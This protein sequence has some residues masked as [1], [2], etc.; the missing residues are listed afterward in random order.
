MFAYIVRRLVYMIPIILGV[1]ILVFIL[2]STVGEDPVRLALGQHASEEAI[3][4]LQH[5]WG[6][7]QP[8]WK[9]YLNFLQQVVTFEFGR[10]FNTGE[11]LNVMFREGALISLSVTAPP[12]VAGIFIN[13]G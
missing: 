11:S 13:T 6:L 8:Y 1:S 4:Q 3:A 9:Q 10:S 12:F 5:K 2:F 7:D